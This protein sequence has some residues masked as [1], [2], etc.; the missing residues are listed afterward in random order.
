M[1]GML[2][3]GWAGDDE[4]SSLL[5]DGSLSVP[6]SRTG[7]RSAPKSGEASKIIPKAR[8]RADIGTE[9]PIV[10][11]CLTVDV[12]YELLIAIVDEAM[13]GHRQVLQQT[14]IVLADPLFDARAQLPGQAYHL[15]GLLIRHQACP[16]VA[17]NVSLLTELLELSND[18]SIGANHMGGDWITR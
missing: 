7:S 3:S 10:L 4:L 12:V 18:R 16:F 2:A 8:G 1:L 13:R 15:V 5:K 14:R 11:Y 6:S 9:S 17:A